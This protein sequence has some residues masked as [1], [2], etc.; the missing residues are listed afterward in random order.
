MHHFA[1]RSIRSIRNFALGTALA[2]ATILP[3][4]AA[5]TVVITGTPVTLA[6]APV[7]GDFTGVTL[8]GAA[9]TTVAAFGTYEVDD[10]SGTGAGW[11]VSAI[12]TQFKEYSG[13]AY[14]ASGKTLAAG[15][16]ALASGAVTPVAGT[17]SPSPTVTGGTLDTATSI[18]IAS[19]A[20]GNGMGKYSFA[21]GT[22]TLSIPS[23]TYARTYKSDLTVTVTS[24]P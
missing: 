4:F 12:S 14:V 9:Q 5:G 17:T 20:V 21:A 24:A 8:N 15:S 16:L 2:A 10:L 19:A 7:L 18:S 6:P 23:N 1:Q 13:T 3:A 22:I 11:H